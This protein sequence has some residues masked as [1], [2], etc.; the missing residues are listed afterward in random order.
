MIFKDKNDLLASG[1]FGPH[2]LEE[3]VKQVIEIGWLL[4]PE[5]SQNAEALTKMITDV[6]ARQL[7]NL[8]SIVEDLR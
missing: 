6:L 8:D 2:V 3:H 4:L 1:M 7:K 5:E